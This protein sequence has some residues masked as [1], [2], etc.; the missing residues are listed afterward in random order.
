MVLFVHKT[1]CHLNSAEGPFS[2][3]PSCSV[4]KRVFAHCGLVERC[5]RICGV[6]IILWP[7]DWFWYLWADL[8]NQQ[9]EV[10]NLWPEAGHHIWDFL[11]SKELGPKEPSKQTFGMLSGQLNQRWSSEMKL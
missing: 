1:L 8:A 2:F 9:P 3:G 6:N 7:G 10:L 4:R 5:R 11:A